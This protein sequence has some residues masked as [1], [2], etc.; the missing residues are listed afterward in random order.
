MADPHAGAWTPPKELRFNDNV[1]GEPSALL[2]SSQA[3]ADPG[4]PIESDPWQSYGWDTRGTLRGPHLR[5]TAAGGR[6]REMDWVRAGTPV[7]GKGLT[8]NSALASP[9]IA[10][11]GGT[12]LTGA[13]RDQTRSH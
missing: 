12:A 7:A 10:V 11:A 13:T 9:L 2:A 4:T 3:N 5:P 6:C 8:H 1:R